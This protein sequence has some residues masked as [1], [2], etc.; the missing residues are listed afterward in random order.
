MEGNSIHLG[1]LDYSSENIGASA[2][3]GK[4]EFL[5]CSPECPKS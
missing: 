5:P 2:P 3:P 1:T 4:A